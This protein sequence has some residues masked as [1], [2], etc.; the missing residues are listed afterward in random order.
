MDEPR[1]YRIDAFTT[2]PGRGNPAGVV[3]HADALD[4]ARMQAIA[5]E[6][7]FSETAFVLQA[8]GDDHD[9]RLRFF[10]P[11]TEV[12]VCGHATVG[13]H[14]ALALESGRTGR[15]RQLTGAGVQTVEVNA[16]MGDFTVRIEQGP[17]VFH[18]PLAPHLVRDVMAALGLEAGDFD[19]RCPLQVVGTGHG[20]LM[21]A[22]ERRS[23][24]V[25]LQPDFDRLAALSPAIGSNGYFVFTLDVDEDDDALCH[26]RMFAP[27]IGVDEDPVTGNANGPLGAYLVRHGLL[28]S[29]DGV[30]RFRARQQAATGR[31]GYVD[32]EVRVRNGEPVDVAITGH[33]ELGSQ[34]AQLLPDSA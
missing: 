2:E 33:A 3:T 28:R 32:V 12:P 15:T 17:P 9:V 27:A 29:E 30:V 11:T 24:L 22:L 16:Y 7:G 10:T 8:S 31:G 26:G 20:K 23:R 19:F 13:A 18:P 5:R 6:M 34:V 14:Y 1:L 21:V 4:E 25:E